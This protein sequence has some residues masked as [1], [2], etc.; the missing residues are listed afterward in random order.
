MNG[1]ARVHRSC[2]TVQESPVPAR[3]PELEESPSQAPA[4]IITFSLRQKFDL[5]QKQTMIGG[6]RTLSS[7]YLH[8]A[9]K[10][11]TGPE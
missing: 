11:T 9:L 5:L 7:H 1:T 3:D 6:V 8:G 10:T 2:Q 4:G